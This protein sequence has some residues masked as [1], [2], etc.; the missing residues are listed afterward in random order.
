MSASGTLSSTPDSRARVATVALPALC[1]AALFVLVA[2]HLGQLGRPILAQD[3]LQYL[4]VAENFSRGAGLRTS[5]IH[6]D[7]ERSFG[8]IPAPTTTFAIGYPF[9]IGVVASTGISPELAGW[10]VS[11]TATAVSLIVLALFARHFALPVLAQAVLLGLFSLNSSTATFSSAVL[12]DAVF[13]AA[14]LAG[15]YAL[16]LSLA[17]VRVG[18]PWVLNAIAAGACFGLAYW[19]R[20]AGLFLFAG[21]CACAVVFVVLGRR[22]GVPPLV[23]SIFVAGIAIGAGLL[24]N[25]ILVG[26]WKGGNNKIVHHPVGEVA[27]SFAVSI[28]DLLVGD[29][30]ASQLWTLRAACVVMLAGVL[31]AGAVS[32]L[33]RRSAV[34]APSAPLIPDTELLLIVIAVSYL[35]CL[36]F[37]ATRTMI[38]VVARYVLPVLPILYLLAI[39]TAFDCRPPARPATA[40]IAWTAFWV[41]LLACY[42][43]VHVDTWLRTP[44]ADATIAAD[45]VLDSRDPTGLTA[46]EIVLGAAGANGTI[47]STNGQ[48]IGYVLQRPTVSLVSPLFSSHVW[49]EHYLHD[50]VSQFAARVLIIGSANVEPPSSPF[51]AHLAN[52]Q[53]PDW[54]TPLG[55]TDR[56]ALYR[57][58]P[59]Q[60]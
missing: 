10:I 19:F 46:R 18:R 37:T 31:L 41:A 26:T 28:R 59:P 32:R 8:V 15:T 47:V 38:V 35:F 49:D 7:E 30:E 12:S 17:A 24:R 23:L 45:E 5:L 50:T 48:A 14:G 44:R 51:L 21:I 54:L 3:S 60:H 53:Y 22:R 34:A 9:A 29:L 20:Y 27:R 11:A 55:R 13:T 42:G 4:S 43:V 36:G 40:R 56:A 6:F 57:V 39:R 58:L 16:A 2:V 1:A 52:G 25:V 33:R